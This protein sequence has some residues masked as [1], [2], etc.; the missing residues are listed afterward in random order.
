MR[1]TYLMLIGSI[2]LSACGTTSKSK[3]KL[4]NGPQVTQIL[5][6]KSKRELYLL[7]NNTV[8]EKYSVDL[9]FAPV[10][11]KAIE[12]DGRTPE[13]VYRVNRRNPNSRFHLSI[14][15]SYPNNQDRAKAKALGKS[16]GGDIFIHG[17][18][19]LAI[20]RGKRDWTA[21]CIS[22]TNK[23]IEVIYA[24]VQDGT[25]IFIKP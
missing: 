9:G 25:P 6:D 13:G 21:G 18:P 11:H 8:L 14:G 7:N 10:G 23:E 5:L 2:A 12:G 19:R 16:P 4:Y 3:F 17:G 15:I 1:L 22:V 20:N 24:M